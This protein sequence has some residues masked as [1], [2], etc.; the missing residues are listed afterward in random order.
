MNKLLI[1]LFA[2]SVSISE[3]FVSLSGG[4]V[5]VLGDS[6]GQPL[7]SDTEFA[8]VVALDGAT[9]FTGLT[10]NE[11]VSTG[12]LIGGGDFF[13]L[14]TG[15]AIDQPLVDGVAGQVSI[16]NF[17]TEGTAIANDVAAGNQV[18]FIWFP[19]LSTSDNVLDAGDSYGFFTAA[20]WLLP[21]G[22]GGDI[23]LTSAPAPPNTTT[24]SAD[25]IVLIPEPSS[26]AL[27]GLGGLALL[28]RRR[29]A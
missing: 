1:T 20:D 6:S 21:T 24:F 19:E 25:Q 14:Q 12:S 13:V 27:L 26:T 4:A 15:T 29:R 10:A 17:N 16:N 5:F 22:G 11:T 8:V 2:A 18:G 28:A 23:V 7:P 9:P 3:A